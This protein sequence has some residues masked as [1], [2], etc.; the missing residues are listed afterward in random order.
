L[1]W[2]TGFEENIEKY[3]VEYSTNG[4]DY[5]AAGELSS[6]YGSAGGAY[7]FKHTVNN[8]QVIRYRLR[9]TEL[10]NKQSYSPVISL[11]EVSKK[12]I[13]V[14]PTV[15]SGGSINIISTV[16]V[17]RLSVFTLDGKEIYAK[18]MA[19]STGYTSIPLS[20]LKKGFYLLKLA[21]D[22]FSQTDKIIIE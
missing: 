6:K 16:P 3:I 9:I 15:V 5:Q 4:R 11:G 20:G 18:Y 10:D 12:R 14:Y 21:G 7:T 13:Q 22:G 1:N 19:G 17:M 8:R 2:T